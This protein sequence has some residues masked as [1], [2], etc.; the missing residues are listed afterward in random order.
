[1]AHIG[2]IAGQIGVRLCR[3]PVR[4]RAGGAACKNNTEGSRSEGSAATSGTNM[5]AY[6]KRGGG[7]GVKGSARVSFQNASPRLPLIDTLSSANYHI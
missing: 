4:A 7:G 6:R 3:T 2:E 1:M 5:S